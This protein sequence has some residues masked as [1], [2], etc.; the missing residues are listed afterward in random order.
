MLIAF[1][2]FQTVGFYGFN[3]WVPSFLIKQGIA[4]TA[5]LGYTFVIAIAA[6]FGPLMP[7]CSATAWSANGP[8]WAAR[9]ASPGF[10]LIFG[11][12]RE[13][14]PLIVFGVLVTLSNNIMSFSFH[15]YQAE[16]YP[17]RNPRHG[18]GFVYSFSGSRPCSAPSSSRS[19]STVSGW[20][21][22]SR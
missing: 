19:S 3:N 11:Q 4:V 9:C 6:P 2:L 8:S 14:V 18:R 5:S 22:C 1:N 20:P 21:A 7:P 15:A 10:G 17:T 16:L 12:A 13:A